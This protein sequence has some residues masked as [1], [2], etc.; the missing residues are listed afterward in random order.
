MK[1]DRWL[2]WWRR[3]RADVGA[4]ACLV[5]FFS[6]CFG[7]F[8]WRG[9]FLIGGDV[10]FYTHPL[11]TVAWEM[12][13]HGQWPLWTPHVLSGY[14]LL[15]MT[16]LGL[17]YP[18]TWAHLLLPSHWAE[19][20]YVLAPFL[21]A[22]T[23]TYVYARTIKRTRTAALL[24]ALSFGYGGL[25]T[26]T[27]GM[28]G[29]PT[30]AL[31]WLPLM[32]AVL[33][34]ARTG[35]FVACLVNATLIY[36]LSVL[37]GHGQSFM[38]VG[39]LALAY[40]L[41][42]ALN[43][44]AEQAEVEGQEIAQS[45]RW[46]PLYVTVGALVL[47]CGVAAF[48]ILETLRATRRS[49]RSTLSY[50]FFSAGGF[51]P[52]EA[53]RSFIAPLYHYTEVTTYQ[54]PLVACLAV[55][56]LVYAVRVRASRDPRIFFWL[57]VALVAFSLLLGGHT[58][59]YR[60]LYRVPVFNLFRRPTRYACEWTFAVS[61]LAAYG[62]DALAP[63]AATR[64]RNATAHAVKGDGLKVLPGVLLL[65]F[66]AAL[67]M[68]WWRAVGHGGAEPSYL[69][70]KLCF[71]L[72]TALALGYGW[73][74]LGPHAWGAWVA[75]CALLL[76]C[77]VE[78]FI[79]INQWWP[80]TAKPGARFTT[81]ALTTRWLQQFA[82]T[83]QRVY[84]RANGA[85]EETSS[86]PRFDA[87]NRT[88]L[89]NLHN[90]AGY[91]QL[92]M[93]RYSRALGHVD[94]DSLSPRPGFAPTRALFEPRSHVLDLLNTAYVVA[95]PDL[96]V[97]PATNVIARDGVNFAADDLGLTIAPGQTATLL[98]ANGV[99]DG[100]SLVTSLA[101][102]V[103][104]KQG[105]T[106]ARLRV[107][108]N[109]GRSIERELRAGIDT[110]EW[111]HERADVRAAMQHRLAPVFDEV[112]GDAPNSFSARRYWTRLPLDASISVKRIEIENVAPQAALALWKVTLYDA[113][114]RR[115][116]PLT[117]EPA[118][119]A[120]LDGARWQV[121]A[122]MDGVLIL[123][124]LRAC[125]R[126]WLVAEGEAVDGEEALRRISGASPRAFD[127]RRTA[128]LEVSPDELPQLS[129]AAATWERMMAHVS[130]YE[131]SHLVIDTDALAPTV[132]VVSE[133]FYPGWAATV[134][135][136]PARIL[137]TDYL[138]RGVALPPGRHRVEMRYTA[139]AARGGAIISACT[140]LLLGGLFVY[141][142]RRPHRV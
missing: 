49:I 57:A 22:P 94:F 75:T 9:Q 98:G 51:T 113:A 18:L 72:T 76:I 6:A 35:R 139:P 134:D 88:A 119:T 26:N 99:G 90:V 108:T 38:Q 3:R 140:L 39:T 101:N 97:T 135:G 16:Q 116:T 89:F 7:R 73:R 125:P 25:M 84:V 46:R 69:G 31:M 27:N 118:A 32:L 59:L 92:F 138:L 68:C 137:L 127:P 112:P 130:A 71:T 133:I 36:S 2:E 142:R 55:A 45:L 61:I 1:R 141:S 8:I 110:A 136:Q 64:V 23:F 30:N 111:A 40:A 21:L 102:S 115:S 120:A 54:A 100:L 33:E 114:A 87:L 62:W 52:P 17:G 12:I 19:E 106:V 43:P 80:G 20:I 67:G 104:I 5:L 44:S 11:R 50:D 42:L 123:R 107:F 47:A 58:P 126:A 109:D 86:Q 4:C 117:N 65:L 91:E 34:R 128:L 82:P 95:W 15:A 81:P 129:G 66:S 48:Q 103:V 122:E 53:L 83:E 121:A 60:L 41:F 93:E 28:N 77:F 24:A 96:A 29:I 78:P 79:L 37:T 14:P 105:T 74:V 132:L 70:W 56:G 10:F 124:N 85:E 13:R 131:P 63:R